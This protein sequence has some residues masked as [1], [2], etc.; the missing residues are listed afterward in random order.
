M[1]VLG[2]D[3]FVLGEDVFVLGGGVLAVRGG[4]VNKYRRGE[5]GAVTAARLTPPRGRFDSTAVRLTGG[6]AVMRRGRRGDEDDEAVVPLIGRARRSFARFPSVPR[7]FAPF[8]LSSAS[9]GR[10]RHDAG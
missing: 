5:G 9:T 3:A 6:R 4:A 2:E 8:S 10:T 7:R 1:F